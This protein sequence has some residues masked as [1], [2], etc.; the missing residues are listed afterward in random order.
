MLISMSTISADA[1]SYQ[2]PMIDSGGAEHFAPILLSGQQTTQANTLVEPI[3][4]ADCLSEAREIT[5]TQSLKDLLQADIEV[6]EAN[7]AVMPFADNQPPVAGLKYLIMNADSLLDGQITTQTQIAWLWSYNGENF[8]YDPDGDEI[9]HSLGGIS[10]NDII[11]FLSGN[12]GF[13]TQFSTPAQYIMT[14]QVQ[15]VHGAKSNI[16]S[17]TIDV[18]SPDGRARPNCVLGATTLTPHANEVMAIQ[19]GT[20]DVD[21]DPI[22]SVRGTVVDPNGVQHPF[23]DYIVEI[24]GKLQYDANVAYLKFPAEGNYGFS[25][26]VQDKYGAWSNWGK[27]TIQVASGELIFSGITI[28]GDKGLAPI[29]PIPDTSANRWLDYRMTLALAQDE[30]AFPDDIWM[31][32]TSFDPPNG[33]SGEYLSYYF[34][35]SGYLKYKD[36]TPK[37]NTTVDIK[38]PLTN[39]L[40]YSLPISTFRATAVT[41][42]NGYFS[43]TCNG[44]DE[45]FK[46][47]GYKTVSLE[48]G[49]GTFANSAFT[50]SLNSMSFIVGT[51]LYLSTSA[52]GSYNRPVMGLVG[53]FPR[54]MMGGHY[55]YIT[56]LGLW[57][58]E[59]FF[60]DV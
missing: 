52:G 51:N 43:Y 42:S 25:M 41:N 45:Y 9:S 2:T 18:E 5:L 30:T 15:D 50:G 44:I 17:Y 36:G 39:T 13:V 31:A 26:S 29:D 58:W 14:Y 3:D 47:L 28:T 35:I 21:G 60:P 56:E 53:W 46:K 16:V 57:Q 4:I 23:T 24:D 34:T 10:N 22:V 54:V 19:Y 55:I 1:V 12:I 59:K 8:S 33:L 11:G 38:V 20:T 37:A 7:S 32:S 49:I 48:S 27:F 40:Y 6:C